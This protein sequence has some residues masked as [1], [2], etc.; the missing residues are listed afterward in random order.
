M[1]ESQGILKLIGQWAWEASRQAESIE[2]VLRG[3]IDSCRSVLA[4]EIA[5]FGQ[6]VADA[7]QEPL[8]THLSGTLK[9]LFGCR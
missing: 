4:P 1:K 5:F 3:R 7:G 6:G 8:P 2:F 9:F